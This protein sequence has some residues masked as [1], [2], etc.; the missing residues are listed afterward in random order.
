MQ[1]SG[2][3]RMNNVENQY[4]REIF[5]LKSCDANKQKLNREGLNAIFEMVGFMPNDKQT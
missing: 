1:S 4:F 3:A 5:Q 2:G